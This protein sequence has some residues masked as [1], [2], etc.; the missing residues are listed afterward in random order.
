MDLDQFIESTLTSIIKGVS[1][2]QEFAKENGG[3]INPVPIRL[4]SIP[5]DPYYVYYGNDEGIKPLTKISFDVAVTA[6]SGD[7]GEGGV[8]IKVLSFSASGSK[9]VE[10]T[11]EIASRVKF[12]INAVLPYVEGPGEK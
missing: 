1:K 4:N 11:N 12:E 10:N 6:S 2:A 7:S 9:S 8:G 5:G 3:R